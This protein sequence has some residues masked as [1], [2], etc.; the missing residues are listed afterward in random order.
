MAVSLPPAAWREPGCRRTGQGQQQKEAE[1]GDEDVTVGVKTEC[2][3]W[4]KSDAIILASRP[5]HTQLQ[6]FCPPN[7][8]GPLACLLC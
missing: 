7:L 4:G 8:W 2:K 1:A 6:L 5:V 3:K